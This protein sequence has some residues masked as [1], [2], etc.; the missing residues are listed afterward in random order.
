MNQFANLESST[1]LENLRQVL[2]QEALALGNCA[3]QLDE[4]HVHVVRAILACAGKVVVTGLGKSGLVGRKIVATLTSTGTPAVFLHAAEALH[5]DLGIVSSQDLVWAISKSGEQGE[6]QAMMPAVRRIGAKVIAMT[7]NLDSTL[8]QAGEFH[9]HLPMDREACP[10]DLAPTVS[11]TL[12]LALGD[13]IAMAV[14]RA[15][16]FRSEDF[17]LFHPGGKLGRRL[18]LQVQDLMLPVEHCPLLP[19]SSSFEQMLAALTGYGIGLVMF[20]ESNRLAG[21]LT[22]GDVRR[23]L[24]K[25]KANVFGITAEQAM[26]RRPFVLSAAQRAYDALEAMENHK[27]PLNVAPVGDVDGRI[28]GAVRLHDLLQAG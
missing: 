8:A 16:G 10:H 28:V 18:L 15:R 1:I 14:M 4:R 13:A 21:I 27:P 11:S 20:G 25:E 5:G 9:L 6:L 24:A 19:V 23:L 17:A 3:G 22:D 26:I 12:S 2:E 7:A